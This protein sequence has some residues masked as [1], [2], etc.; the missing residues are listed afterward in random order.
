MV[1]P[2]AQAQRSGNEEDDQGAPG[3]EQTA[4]SGVGRLAGLEHERNGEDRCH[5]GHRDLGDQD[6]RL[7]AHQFSFVQHRHNR[8]RARGE[9]D[10][11]PAI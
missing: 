3:D 10:R 2:A 1:N 11:T 6:Q 5:V 9:K 7:W 4:T 8:R